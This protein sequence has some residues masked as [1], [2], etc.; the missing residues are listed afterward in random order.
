MLQYVASMRGLVHG[1]RLRLDR[2]K[3]ACFDFDGAIT[4]T[5]RHGW[6]TRI[7][8]D[9]NNNNNNNNK[10]LWGLL[11]GEVERWAEE[12]LTVKFWGNS[13]GREHRGRRCGQ[14]DRHRHHSPLPPGGRIVALCRGRIMTRCLFQILAEGIASKSPWSEQRLSRTPFTCSVTGTA[15][16]PFSSPTRT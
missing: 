12:G 6:K 2:N 14:D 9:D 3:S 5:F 13:K 4:G 11:L 16:H 15:H 7:G 1:L 8:H 10:D